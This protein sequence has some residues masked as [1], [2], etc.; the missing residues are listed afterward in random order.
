[1]SSI[2]QQF[3][4]MDYTIDEMKEGV[5]EFLTNN[6]EVTASNLAVRI[7]ES[8]V[9]IM[10]ASKITGISVEEIIKLQKLPSIN[11]LS[12]YNSSDVSS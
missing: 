4:E 8:G 10:Y 7:V 12:I 2:I 3:I 6:T 9:D 11:F 1:M 5:I